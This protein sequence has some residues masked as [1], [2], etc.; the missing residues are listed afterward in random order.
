MSVLVY[1]ENW[2][3]GFKKSSFELVS[4]ASKLGEILGTNVVALSIGTVADS[5]LKN[6]AQYGADKILNVQGDQ[7][8]VLDN[9]LFTQVITAAADKEEAQVVILGH[10]N[11]GKAL[12]P[13][14]SMRMKA[15]LATAVNMLP[16]ST[17]PFVVQKKVF[18]G[19]ANTKL[20]IQ[21]EKQ[22]LTLAQN[23]FE[24]IENNKE[25]S[26]EAFDPHTELDSKTAVKSTNK[27]S[28]KILLTD[29]EIVI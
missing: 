17:E 23:S 11:T 18:S 1:T 19:K 12:A 22:L 10:S 9:Q 24:V 29:A 28:G 20:V 5:E 8:T 7:F 3:G 27:Q 6:L 26:I 16:E 13:R 21:S 25:A 14:L 2:D 15:G 4:Y